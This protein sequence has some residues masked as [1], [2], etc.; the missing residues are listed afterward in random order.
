[1]S[2]MYIIRFTPRAKKQQS[3]LQK[4][5]Q[6]KLLKQLIFLMQDC[7]HP[8]LY[9]KRKQGENR[10]EARIDYHYRF[11]FEVQEQTIINLSVGM[12]DVGLGKK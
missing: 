9:T 4:P 10:W 1:M 6:Q 5:T 11:T 8:S 12:H 3:K 2:S 7:H